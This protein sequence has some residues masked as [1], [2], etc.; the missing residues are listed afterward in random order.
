[1]NWRWTRWANWISL[2]PICI[3]YPDKV[4]VT[5]SSTSR[6][7]IPFTGSWLTPSPSQTCFGPQFGNTAEIRQKPSSADS[8][9][10]LESQATKNLIKRLGPRARAQLRAEKIRVQFSEQTE[11]AGLQ[12]LGRNIEY[13]VV[14]SPL[15]HNY[16]SSRKEVCYYDPIS[17]NF[18]FRGEI[19]N[20]QDAAGVIF[21]LLFEQSEQRCA[22]SKKTE[23]N[24]TERP[25]IPTIWFFR[26]IHFPNLDTQHSY[27]RK[28][29]D[30]IFFV[31]HLF[32]E[33]RLLV[34]TYWNSTIQ[35]S[36]L[37]QKIWSLFDQ[38]E[39]LPPLARIII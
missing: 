8:D 5:K 9:K 27:I 30:P 37:T 22:S 11:R 33:I 16:R 28:A 12:A 36:L 34:F 38:I 17:R 29:L 4:A 15:S 14:S 2:F 35:L 6:C 19:Y 7:F 13:D 1:V 25:L 23:Q 31:L 32:I 10:E 21:K 39:R 18:H 24:F 20:I 3:G 26:N